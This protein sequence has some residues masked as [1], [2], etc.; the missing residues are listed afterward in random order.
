MLTTQRYKF[1]KYLLAD[2]VGARF[3]KMINAFISKFGSYLT[4]TIYN[5]L[6]WKGSNTECTYNADTAIML[7]D[8]TQAL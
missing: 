2:Y 3:S 7:A 6:K 5:C 4:N 8:S 1:K